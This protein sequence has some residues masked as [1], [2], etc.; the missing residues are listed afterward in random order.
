MQ[1][2]D[3]KAIY[4][5]LKRPDVL[6]SLSWARTHLTDAQNSFTEYQNLA[7]TKQLSQEKCAWNVSGKYSYLGMFL[8]D[9]YCA[10]ENIGLTQFEQPALS[11]RVK[12]SVCEV[13]AVVLWD[14]ERLVLYA[15]V[16]ILHKD[17][18]RSWV[19]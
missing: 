10:A 12:E 2:S 5:T 17:R 18:E 11:V 19:Y 4:Y 13:V 3:L 16:Q 15:I 8:L 7:R 6:W 14:F 9:I 1:W